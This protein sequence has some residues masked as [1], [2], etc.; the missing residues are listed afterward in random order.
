[1]RVGALSPLLCCRHEDS[2]E[3]R[4]TCP[5]CWICNILAPLVS[6]GSP[7]QRL[8]QSP[9]QIIIS[10]YH[11]I[12]ISLYSTP[13]GV[14]IRCARLYK[15]KITISLN[16]YF[17]TNYHNAVLI[18]PPPLFIRRLHLPGIV[19]IRF[20]ISSCVIRSHSSCKASLTSASV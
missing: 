1:M 10:L 16:C 11:Y 20:R 18:G 12:I 2:R 3:R 9:A 15:P 13:V 8:I 7:L 19:A 4:H 6:G 17:I 14:R 5:G